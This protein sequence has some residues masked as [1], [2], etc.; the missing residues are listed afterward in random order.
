MS[1]IKLF[2]TPNGGEIAIVNGQVGMTDGL[3]TAAFLSL[4]GGN[5][6]DSAQTADDPK[7]WW[8]NLS[9]T[10]LTKRFR[11]A[12]QYLLS[13]LPLIPA[14]LQRIEEAAMSDLAWM[15]DS[16]ATDLAV[17]ATMPGPKRINLDCA[18]TIDGNTTSFTLAKL[19]YK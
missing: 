12:T 11:S 9:E 10:D 17:R 8:G 7:Q 15:L 19:S 5:A 14:N 4:F 2:E 6:D 18:L 3:E 13:T 16:V 1:D